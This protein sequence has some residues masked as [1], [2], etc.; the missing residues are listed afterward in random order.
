MRDKYEW[1]IDDDGFVVN[2][3]GEYITGQELSKE[4]HSFVVNDEYKEKHFQEAIE[5]VLSKNDID[6]HSEYKVNAK[7]DTHHSHGRRADIYIPDTDTAIEL[8]LFADMSGLGQATYYAQY[9]REAVLMVD[10][11]KNDIAESIRSIPGVYF[12]E[13]T[14]APHKEELHIKSDSRCEFFTSCKHGN[15]GG[16]SW[17]SKSPEKDEQ[18]N[19]F[20]R[21]L[22]EFEE[23]GIKE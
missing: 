14:P 3:N 21:T 12:C 10:N 17:F 22:S 16:D 15:L 18:I 19:E 5:Y 4:H 2:Q 11:C 23:T 7:P 20:T 13:S 8:K 9:H 1:H 6:Y